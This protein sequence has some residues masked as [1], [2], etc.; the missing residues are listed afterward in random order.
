MA[1]KVMK[2]LYQRVFGSRE[3][4]VVLADILNDCGFF[5]LQDISS[6][7]LIRLNVARRILGKIGV[8][9]D[10]NA[11]HIAGLYTEEGSDLE[12]LLRLKE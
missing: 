5:S 2:E 1:D 3:G 10:E 4:K 11:I 7:D 6:E 9:T 8:W 12:D